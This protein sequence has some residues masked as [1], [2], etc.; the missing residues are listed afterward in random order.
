[1]FS[2]LGSTT[3]SELCFKTFLLTKNVL[4]WLH[5]F[6]L[7]ATYWNIN[8]IKYDSVKSTLS[9]HDIVFILLM[10]K[11]WMHLCKI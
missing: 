5:I 3:M 7:E 9:V 4:F 1:M 10:P 2:S 6:L 8:L 11:D